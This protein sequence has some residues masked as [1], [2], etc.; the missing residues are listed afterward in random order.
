MI[1]YCRPAPISRFTLD[2]LCSEDEL[3]DMPTS[4]R[5]HPRLNLDLG[6][7]FLGKMN[8]LC[9]HCSTLHWMNEKLTKSNETRP[10]FGTCSLQGKIKLPGLITPPPVLQALYDKDND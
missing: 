3:E 5:A 4:T 9:P 7:H 8:I 2:D 1:N 10:L 6:R